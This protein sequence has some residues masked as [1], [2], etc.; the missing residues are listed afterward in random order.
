VSDLLERFVLIRLMR[1]EGVCRSLKARITRKYGG[2]DPL[3]ASALM[4]EAAD[5]IAELERKL[6]KRN[7]RLADF[8]AIHANLEQQLAHTVE[9]NTELVAELEQEVER[10]RTS[11][12]APW[13]PCM[14]PDG[15]EPCEQYQELAARIAELEQAQSIIDW[16][17]AEKRIAEL[18]NGKTHVPACRKVMYD[19]KSSPCTCRSEFERMAEES[20]RRIAALESPWVS[21]DERLPDVPV[22]I[23]WC[24]DHHYQAYQAAGAAVGT[25]YS[26]GGWPED[27]T[28]WM[29]LPAPPEAEQTDP[30]RS[31]NFGPGDDITK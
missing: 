8:R 4:D 1:I 23:M 18:E 13:P 20:D 30:L 9:D 5:R 12:Q 22:V 11:K 28:H 15:A 25:T 19:M 10:F 31:R 16:V 24:G 7:R 14:A 17:A 27:M 29:P 2:I 6:K 3:D 26:D 21:V